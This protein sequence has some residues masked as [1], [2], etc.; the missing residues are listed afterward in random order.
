MF[1]FIF[2]SKIQ[3]KKGVKMFKIFEIKDLIDR[4]DEDVL[5]IN[6]LQKKEAELKLAY[7]KKHQEMRTYNTNT[8]TCIYMIEGEIKLTFNN[9][10]YSC[11]SFSCE[12]KEHEETKKELETKTIEKNQLFLTEKELIHSIEA[13]KNSTFLIIKI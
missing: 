5:L 3:E 7:L 6:L 12:L 8:N 2:L 10:E 4:K 13:L 9:E 11:N 1:L